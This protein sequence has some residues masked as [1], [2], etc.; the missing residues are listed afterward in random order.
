MENPR[1]DWIGRRIELHAA[2]DRWMMGDRYGRICKAGRL[3]YQ[4]TMD[5]SGQTIRVSPDDLDLLFD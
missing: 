1:K 2:T 3:Y 5:R 4:V